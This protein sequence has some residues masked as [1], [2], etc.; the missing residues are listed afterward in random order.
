LLIFWPIS[1]NQRALNEGGGRSAE[2]AKRQYADDFKPRG[3]G[4]SDPT[5]Q[6][7]RPWSARRP[8]NFILSAV[9]IALAIAL[10]MQSMAFIREG[11]GGLVP[12]L[13]ILGGPSLAAFYTW[14]FTI[15]KFQDD[16]AST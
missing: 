4:M 12:Y 9:L 13:M 10:V 3:A 14:Y 8:Q 5:G 1:Y 7:A 15:R 6:D 2:A 16:S 11:V